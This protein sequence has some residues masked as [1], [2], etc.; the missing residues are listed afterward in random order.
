MVTTNK[1]RY[2]VFKPLLRSFA[3][4]GCRVLVEYP[5]SILHK[6][7]VIS[8]QSGK[9]YHVCLTTE[10]PEIPTLLAGDLNCWI[11]RLNSKSHALIE[12]ME[13]EEP[14]RPD[15]SLKKWARAPKHNNQHSLHEHPY[16]KKSPGK[17]KMSGNNKES[18]Q[19]WTPRKIS[20]DLLIQSIDMEEI[21]NTIEGGNIDDAL[22]DITESLMQAASP[23]PI[24]RNNK[25]WFDRDC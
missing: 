12:L 10:W 8:R 3:L 23:Q 15:F 19:R 24:K 21:M 14:Y 11:D 4:H 13:E 25:P 16:K 22:R 9:N 7:P 18:E 20:L 5:W 17:G 2:R 1:F 6:T